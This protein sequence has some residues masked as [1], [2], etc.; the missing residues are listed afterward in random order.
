MHGDLV[1][2][3]C[4]DSYPEIRLRF[5]EKLPESPIVTFKAEVDP[6]FNGHV[7]L[8]REFRERLGD[9]YNDDHVMLADGQYVPTCCFDLCVGIGEE[10]LS[11]DLVPVHCFSQLNR[12]Q[13]PLVG[14]GLLASYEIC[15]KPANKILRIF[16]IAEPVK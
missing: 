11:S 4:G 8:P 12:L 14:T 1:A 6:G 13:K 15:F 7:L 5:K 9:E 2:E 16:K 10:P 3:S